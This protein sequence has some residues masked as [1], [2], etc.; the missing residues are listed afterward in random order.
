MKVLIIDDEHSVHEQL[1]KLIPWEELGWQIVGHALNG[2]EAKQMTIEFKPHLIITDIKMPLVDGLEYMQWLQNSENPAKV[3]V[4]SGYGDFE[5][6]RPAFLQGAVDYLLK[7]I[8]QAELLKV[9]GQVVGKFNEE[10]RAMEEEINEKAVLQTSIVLLQDQL[11][12][13]I[14]EGTLQEENEMI[15]RAE[16]IL[17]QLPERGYYVAVVRLTD[18]DRHVNLRYERDRS[19]LY[20]AVR[21]VLTE[22]LYGW[23]LQGEVFRNL[24]KTNEFLVLAQAGAE[25]EVQLHE[26]LRSLPGSLQHAVRVKIQIGVSQRKSRLEHI[27]NGYLE[28]V[29]AI[30]SLKLGEYRAATYRQKIGE[31]SSNPVPALLAWKELGEMLELLIKTGSLRDRHALPVKMEQA[32]QEETLLEL[33]G[34]ELKQGV[35]YILNAFDS[36][37]SMPAEDNTLSVLLE[38][39]KSSV[40]EL[41]YDL[42]RQQIRTLIEHV[43]RHYASD[44]KAMSGKQ[45][46]DGVIQYTLDHYRTVTL[47]EISQKFFINKNYFCSLFKKE[48]GDSYLEYL[49]SVRMEE[50]KLLLKNSELKAYEIA[51][52]VGYSDQR[53]FSQVFRK[54]TGMKPTDYR[55]TAVEKSDHLGHYGAQA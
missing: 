28:G 18:L 5:Y 25:R 32:M 10:S 49:T 23:K 45:L 4:L 14:I 31:I 27:R 50:A 29:Q 34:I 19:A 52:L 54:H 8:Q 36:I 6:I 46:V 12:T 1:E 42:L 35:R 26:M 22:C 9:L 21:N 20:Y 24:Q 55:K 37:D 15:V 53:Y 48:T 30:E 41:R 40:N 38:S 33:N 16:Q 47:D 17:L 44:I 51:E 43:L 39:M 11:M 3:I 13:E 7:P 2:E